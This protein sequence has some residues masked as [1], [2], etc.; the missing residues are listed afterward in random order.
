MD[1]GCKQSL[2]G[3]LTYSFCKIAK[4]KLDLVGRQEGR[5]DRGSTEPAGDFAFLCMKLG[6]RIIK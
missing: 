1:M 2:Y 5:W 3:R 4:Y 6:M